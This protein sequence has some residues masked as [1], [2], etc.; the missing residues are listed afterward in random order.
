MDLVSNVVGGISA[1]QFGGNT[2][3]IT[4]GFDADGSVFEELLNKQ[5]NQ[6][7]NIGDYVNSSGLNILDLTNSSLIDSS[8]V[9][10][11]K[12]V[13]KNNLFDNIKDIS[14]SEVLTMFNSL[15]ESKP[16]L[17]DS[18]NSGLFQFERKLAANQY[19]KYAKNVITDLNEF[20]SDAV[21]SK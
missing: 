21:L 6:Q 3:G 14:T 1:S 5:I 10:P 15:F 9:N 11:V 4:A 18:S 13:E 16:S 19:G 12:G 17:T 2:K 8:I 7:N 20:V